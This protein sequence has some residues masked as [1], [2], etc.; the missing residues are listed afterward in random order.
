MIYINEITG[1]PYLEIDEREPTEEE[2]ENSK[3]N[4]V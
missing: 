1:E 3:K 4:K 2:W